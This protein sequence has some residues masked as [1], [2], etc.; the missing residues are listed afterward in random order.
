MGKQEEVK[1][2]TWK[3]FLEQKAKELLNIVLIGIVF[4]VIPL[5]V[6]F[7]TLNI[8]NE[9]L[10]QEANLFLLLF[11]FWLIGILVSLLLFMVG[12]ALYLL[13]SEVIVNWIKSNWV[14]AST[15]ATNEVYGK[16][17]RRY[18]IKNG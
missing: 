2:L 14:K 13:F 18:K 16:S 17:K 4:I 10:P 3:Y 8:F 1:K 12:I 9:P 11:L 5:A 7:L 15:R 6:G